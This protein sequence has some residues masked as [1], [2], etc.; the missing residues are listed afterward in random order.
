M[1]KIESPPDRLIGDPRLYA[2]GRLSPIPSKLYSSSISPAPELL[3]AI[4]C[5]LWVFIFSLNSSK[6]SIFFNL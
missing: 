1:R 5:F 6:Q 2:I 4:F 3:R